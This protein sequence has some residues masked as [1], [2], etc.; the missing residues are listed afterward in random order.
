[1]SAAHL[2]RLRSAIARSNAHR[3]LHFAHKDFSI[4]DLPCLG[5]QQNCFNGALCDFICNDHLELYFRK[6][7]D[8]LFGAAINFAVPFLPAKAFHLAESHSFHARRQKRF[9]HRLGFKGL[10]DRLDLFHRA[11]LEPGFQIASTKG[12]AAANV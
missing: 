10:D 2:Q 6:E 5:C 7:I 12:A 4:T 8:C 1:V 11:K 3:L 9:L